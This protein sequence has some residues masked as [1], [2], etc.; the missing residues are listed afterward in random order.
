MSAR[1]RFQPWFRD[2]RGF[3]VERAVVVVTRGIGGGAWFIPVNDWH[4]GWVGWV[5]QHIPAERLP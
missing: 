1:A 2:R 4:G 5:V 3:D